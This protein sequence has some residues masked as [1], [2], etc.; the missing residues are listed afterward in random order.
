MAGSKLV[1]EEEGAGMAGKVTMQDIADAL[2][3]SRNTVSK[4]VNDTGGL[5]DATREKVLKKAIELGYKQFSYVKKEDSGEEEKSLPEEM[6]S[7]KTGTARLG[8]YFT[9]NGFAEDIRKSDLSCPPASRGMI[10]M[11]TTTMPGSKRFSSAMFDKFQ[12]ELLRNGYGFAI[13]MVGEDE[14]KRLYLP[15]SFSRKDTAGIICFEM[16]DRSY[17]DMLCE[18]GLPV[19]FVDAP[20]SCCHDAPKADRLLMDNR[21][22]IQALVE[23]MVRRGK[24]KIGFIG[25]TNYSQ[26]FRERYLAC[27]DAF[28]LL[29]LP[30]KKEW[31]ITGYRDAEEKTSQDYQ[32]YLTGKLG[33]LKKLPDV[34][35]CAN[36]QVAFCVLR[37][38]RKLGISVPDD[39]YL[40]GF[41]DSPESTIISPSLT[42]VRIHGEI[43]GKSAA[44]LLLSRIQ[45]PDLDYRTVYTE[46]TPVYRGST[47][48]R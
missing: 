21:L 27:L 36:D 48:D 31:C 22:G 3:L 2:K 26:S 32:S 39:I 13:Y 4:A 29:D 18:L 47:G 17:C 35:L 20:A 40:C 43:M 19:L 10:A 12:N 24:R 42:T 46:T 8:E 28:I 37:I 9:E 11:F 15:H 38:L 5:S 7:A 14:V 41:E 25:E 1:H 30:Y 33:N 16:F 34:F 23:E 45:N 44:G 6:I